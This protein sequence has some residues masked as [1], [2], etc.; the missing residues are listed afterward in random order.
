MYEQYNP[1]SFGT[2]LALQAGGAFAGGLANFLRG[3]SDLE[4]LQEDQARLNLRRGE[5]DIRLRNESNLTR[6]GLRDFA[7]QQFDKNIFDPNSL[8]TSM[9]QSIMPMI[10]QM[11][12]RLNLPGGVG[13]DSGFGQT[14]LNENMLGS[15]ARL[16]QNAFIRNAEG[17][18]AQNRY[19]TGLRGHL[20]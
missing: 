17:K 18:A 13:T 15:L 3:K 11:R 10:S 6:R 7:A 2:G 14:R 5:Q 8:R 1:M 4:R 12:S 16:Y 9:M 20:S 19:Y